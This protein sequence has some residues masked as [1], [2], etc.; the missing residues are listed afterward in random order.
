MQ[1]RFATAPRNMP[2][3]ATVSALALIGLRA[4]FKSLVKCDTRPQVKG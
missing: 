1:R 2:D 4:A 3:E